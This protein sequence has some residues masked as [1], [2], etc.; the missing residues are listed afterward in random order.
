MLHSP[1]RPEGKLGTMRRRYAVAGITLGLISM[2]APPAQA[3]DALNFFKNYFVT[4]DYAVGGV[5]LQGTGVNGFATGAIPVSGVPANADILGAFL[6]W[7]TVEHTPG[8]GAVGA[9]FGY[10]DLN[11]SLNDISG[12]AKPLGT[13][14]PPCWSSGGATGGGGPTVQLAVYRADVLRFIP[15][16]PATGKRWVNRVH[17]VMLPDSGTGNST[18]STEGASLV[19]VYRDSAS[20]GDTDMPLKSIV[21]YDG[22][23]TMNQT[24]QTM[25]QTIQGFY[26]ASSTNPA[27]KL[28]HIVG[29]GQLNKT[30]RLLFNGQFV[31][32]N[33]FTG[34]LG[35]AWDN[36]TFDVSALVGGNSASATT[37]VDHAGSSTFDCLSWGAIIFSTTVQDTDNDGLL[38]VWETSGFTDVATGAFVDLPHMG[39]N[40]NVKDIFVQ[41]DY[42]TGADGHAHLPSQKALDMVAAAFQKAPVD[43]GAGIR[44]HFDVGGSYQ[45]LPAD[46]AIIPAAVALGG[47][48]I[49]ESSTC[50][51]SPCAFPT[52]PGTVGWKAGYRLIRDQHLAHSRKDVFH[53]ALFAHT[54]GLPT[55]PGS[56]IP[57]STSGISDL[58]GGDL[59]VTLGLWDHQVGSDFV[60]AATLFHELGHNLALRHGGQSLVPSQS[61]LPNCKPNYESSMNYLF[62]IGGLLDA[63]GVPNIDY[64]R[65]ALPNL[66]EGSLSESAG[67]GVSSMAYQS[68][69][70]LPFG[71]S[72]LDNQLGTTA[73]TR[74][75][76]G[77]SK[78]ATDVTVGGMIRVDSG[79]LVGSPVDWN[80][81]GTTDLGT[82][83]QDL[84]YNGGFSV[85]P[86]TGFNDWSHI[87]LR[88]VGGRRN[89][90]KV[91]L[92]VQKIDLASGDSG[93]G[94]SGLGDS[95]LGDSG[96]GDSGLGD[97]GLGDSGLGDSG[98]GDSGLGAD[99][100]FET[101]KSI[102]NAPSSLRATVGKQIITLNWS[103]PNVSAVTQYRVYRAI[104]PITSTNL[105]AL[106]GTVGI[107]TAGTPPSTTFVDT[108]VKNNVTYTYLVVLT[109]G[110][111]NHSGP[112]NQVTVLMK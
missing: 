20:Y 8:S 10:P 50:T 23:Y 25:T 71:S 78:A 5:G 43:G 18:P 41:V 99:L 27:A 77:T 72:T 82:F 53:Y 98:L 110:D 28:T 74:H 86:F 48:A 42:L 12:I 58:L 40:P 36:P 2:L 7:A 60:Q 102:G 67:F 3:G 55:A 59:M 65:E 63:H 52:F 105:P 16:N 49:P 87:D 92:D 37:V 29:S 97:S 38:D 9:T 106:I 6:Y 109:D 62:Q 39:A 91:S 33:P 54:L 101:A 104:G 76:D 70:Y 56:G 75:C 80:K 57:K 84:D 83:A 94:D 46:T 111:G 66:G 26:Q 73:A 45:T 61:Q 79:S 93:L 64:S 35:A 31:E 69:W 22:S 24:T 90:F 68:R 11:P 34:G 96:L 85:A 21:I 4:G 100:E 15:V 30:E 13:G 47:N 32:T 88:Q 107:V 17:T 44:I 108:N 81:N 14:T 95:G 112:S 103:A 89:V 51:V 1:K 19:I